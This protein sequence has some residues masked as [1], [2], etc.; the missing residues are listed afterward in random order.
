MFSASGFNFGAG[1]P[2]PQAEDINPDICHLPG[3]VLLQWLLAK[4]PEVPELYLMLLSLLLGQPVS[5]MHRNIEVRAAAAAAK[6][7]YSE[8][9]LETTPLAIKYGLSRQVV[10]GDMFSSIEM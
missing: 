10:F 6:Y 1:N 2:K 8:P 3:F 5:D 4:H 7:C 9:V